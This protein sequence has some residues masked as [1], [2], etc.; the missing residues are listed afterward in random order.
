MNA[1]PLSVV[2]SADTWLS[3]TMVWLY[4]QIHGLPE[5]IT[6]HVV[7]NNSEN[8]ERFPIDNLFV[9]NEAT[10]PFGCLSRHS[11]RF[12][13]AFR[14]WR[15]RRIAQSSDCV[16]H[17]HFGDQGW[18]DMAIAQKLDIPHIVTF[19][20][21]DASMLPLLDTHWRK[22]FESL[23]EHA[24]TVLAEGPFFAESLV[25][26][27][28][29]RDKVRIQHLGVRT[30]DIKFKQRLGLKENN[31]IRVLM[32]GSF[33]EKK[34]F[35]DAFNAISLLK[36][37][38]IHIT[39]V[40]DEI[41]QPRSTAEKARILAVLNETGLAAHTNFVGFL[42]YS[43]LLDLSYQHDI[44]LSPSITAADGDAEGGAPVTLIAMAATGIPIVSTSHCDIPEVIV[45]GATGL[46][47]E[48]G[49]VEGLSAALD[50]MISNRER[51]EEFSRA[52]RIH[53]EMEFDSTKQSQRLAAL[54][55]SVLQ[56]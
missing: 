31:V 19:Y 12:A 54:Y 6:S 33:V 41:E 36:G 52:G 28:C 10:A 18:A 37:R 47:A 25:Q 20:G 46:L 44:F 22:R 26:L 34:G 1:E 14:D 43:E 4:D 48:P 21:Y 55:R 40:G 2:Q 8:T 35:P 3:S 13:S 7:A 51:Y 53:T 49:D 15:I 11:Y 23:F 24:T 9:T 30:P 45:D 50:E 38:R 27:G 32:A 39:L 56:N 17:S 16:L 5:D 42:P 29:P